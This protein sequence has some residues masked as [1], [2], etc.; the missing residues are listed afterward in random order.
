MKSDVS[1]DVI[2]AEEV[3]E[4]LGMDVKS[5]YRGARTGEIPCLRVGRKYLFSRSRLASW[6]R[7]EAQA[8]QKEA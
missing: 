4:L 3:A 2:T 6:W 5:V 8:P 1:F 7:G